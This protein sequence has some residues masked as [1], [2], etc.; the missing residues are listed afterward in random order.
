[1]PTFLVAAAEP[2]VRQQL[3]AVLTRTCPCEIIEATD[4]A[5]AL[6][7]A[8]EVSP[9]LVIL[10]RDLPALN[11][12]RVCRTLKADT[13]TREIPVWILS[14]SANP[15]T[16]ARAAAAGAASFFRKPIH[17]AT[18]QTRVREYAARAGLLA[19]S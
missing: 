5:E 11:G 14:G 10:D 15:E 12:L 4:G 19:A 7:R 2:A 6:A 3:R 8:R 13:A 17:S 9:R 16:L 1:M 18:L